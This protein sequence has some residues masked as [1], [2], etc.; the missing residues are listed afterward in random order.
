[1]VSECSNLHTRGSDT[2]DK[3]TYR[4]GTILAHVQ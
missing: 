3:E 2:P 1:M 4:M